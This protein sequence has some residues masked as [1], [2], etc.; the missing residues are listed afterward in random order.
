MRG[1]HVPTIPT[2]GILPECWQSSVGVTSSER[3]ALNRVHSRITALL[4]RIHDANN[5][6][7]NASC[8]NHARTDYVRSLFPNIETR[9]SYSRSLLL[10]MEISSFFFLS[11]RSNVADLRSSLCSASRSTSNA[12]I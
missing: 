7:I 1:L 12:A 9:V 3:L 5:R 11:S 4:R 6:Q 2:S 10:S 8:A